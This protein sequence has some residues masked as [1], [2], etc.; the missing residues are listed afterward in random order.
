MSTASPSDDRFRGYVHKIEQ[1]L[2][3][4]A[5]D[6]VIIRKLSRA[7]KEL[8]ANGSWLQDDHRVGDPD[9]YTRHMLHRDPLGRFLVLALVWQ[10]G[11]ETPIHDHSCWGIM[12]MVEN[13]LEEHAYQRLDDGSRP[14]FCDLTKGRSMDVVQGGVS[15]LLPPHEEIH[16]IGNTSDK[17]AI[18]LH[19]YGRDLDA[20]NVFDPDTGKVSK[21]QIRQSDDKADKR[22]FVV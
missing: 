10:P 20:V 5:P 14:D 17:Q 21:L 16:R 1:L 11:Q 15:Y 22:P 8:C 9:R 3:Q 19:V 13:A 18:S 4:R 7:T 2:E 12:G 6:K